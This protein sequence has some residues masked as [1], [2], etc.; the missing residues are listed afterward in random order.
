M[1]TPLNITEKCPRPRDLQVNLGIAWA[2]RLASGYD[3][4]IGH[5]GRSSSGLIIEG[6]LRETQECLAYTKDADILCLETLPQLTRPQIIS[7]T[8]SFEALE[9]KESL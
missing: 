9:K 2:V 8:A 5:L 4:S 3:G 7:A 6:E 1:T